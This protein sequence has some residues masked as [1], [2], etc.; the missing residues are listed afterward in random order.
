MNSFKHFFVLLF[1]IY[2]GSAFAETWY[3]SDMQYVPLRSGPG[4]DYRIIHKGLPS[5]TAMTII[6]IDRDTGYSKIKT[7]KGTEGWIRSQ[8]LVDEPTAKIQLDEL[9]MKIERSS[10]SNAENQA[11][12]D[13]LSRTVENLETEKSAIEASLAKTAAELTELKKISGSTV[14]INQKNKI[15]LQKNHLLENELDVLKAENQRLE[16]SSDRKMFLQG[17]G[18]VLVAL[19]LGVWLSGIKR[20]KSYSSGW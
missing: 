5:G 4:N 16:Q 15:L 13:E 10:Q 2:S 17:G 8:Y 11:T 18:M 3:V 14:E 12:I 19:L 6:E 1:F 9:K 7:L 20:R